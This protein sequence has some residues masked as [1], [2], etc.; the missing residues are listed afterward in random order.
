[1]SAERKVRAPTR[2]RNDTRQYVDLHEEWWKPRGAFAMLHWIAAAR[3]RHV[4]LAL[5]S[6]SV[7]VDIGCGAGVLAPHIAHLGHR[8]VGIDVVETSLLLARDR[9]VTPVL[10]DARRLPLRDECADVV[11]AGEVLEH[12]TDPALLIA[13][14]T[15]VLKPDGMLVIDTIADTWWGRL[16]AITVGE[17]IPAGPPPRLHDGALFIDR[18]DLVRACEHGGVQL[19][20]NGLRPHARDYALWMLRRREDVRMVSTANTAGLF[21]GHG[22]K[23]LR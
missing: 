22:R 3:A 15:R 9:G 17:R 14:V 8:H 10:A 5:H 7:L 19:T 20:L 18:A 4:P 23:E 1:M 11:V 12:V 2:P 16:S 13:E 21:Q 6:E